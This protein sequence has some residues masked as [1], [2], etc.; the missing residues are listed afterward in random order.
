MKTKKFITIA[1]TTVG[2]MASSIG[3]GLADETT[4]P[5]PTPKVTKTV[6]AAA[7]SNAYAVALAQYKIDLAKYKNDLT[8]Y[9]VTVALNDIKDRALVEKYWLDWAANLATYQAKWKTEI[10]K[11]YADHSAWAA[12]NKP[13]NQARKAALDKAD[14]DFV[15]A[16]AAATTPA[17]QEAA[18]AARATAH[19]AALSVY[20]AAVAQ[21]G[22]EPVA[23][24]KPAEM[25]KPALPAK[26]IDPVKPV[27]PVKPAATPKAT[28]TK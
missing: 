15:A 4:S 28:A 3:V 24:T 11:Y 21:I 23:P 13:L 10:D 7:T 14:S 18:L 26:T 8:Q 22:T 5:T 9:R 6:K 20:K 2:L 27:A 19:A 16:N 1:V 12:K 17:A 25:T